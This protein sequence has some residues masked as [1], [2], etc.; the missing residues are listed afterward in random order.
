M[1]DHT[2]AEELAQNPQYITLASNVKDLTGQRFERL[3]AL[4]PIGKTWKGTVQWLCRCDCGKHS[5]VQ[6]YNL[7]GGSVRSCGCLQKEKASLVWKIHGMRKHPLYGTWTGII[8]RCTNPNS[9]DYIHY[10]GRDITICEEWRHSFEAFH[11][12]VSQ[13]PHFGEKG[14]TL[15]RID[16]NGNYEPGNVRW[17]TWA[18][19][20][21]NTQQNILLTLDGKTR[22]AAVWAEELGMKQATLRARLN[23]GWSAEQ[24]LTTPVR[25]LRR[26]PKQ[27]TRQTKLP[28]RNED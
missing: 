17:A 9:R 14:Y 19:Q 25:T 3:V 28:F 6:G 16:N 24:T 12:H 2:R 26:S 15:D 8:D 23:R 21:R 22:C 7:A 1:Q 20:R 10:G 13:L 18:E 11:D 4:G 27:P 5:I